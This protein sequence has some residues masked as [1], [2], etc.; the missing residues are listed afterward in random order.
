MPA[1]Q[2]LYDPQFEH[3]SCGVG[4]VVDI[5]GRKS[6]RIVTQAL[7]VL[8]NLLH[9][10]ACGCE[11]NTGDGAGI[12]IQMPHAFLARECGKLGITL[13]APRWY[14]AGLVFLPTDPSQ[15]ARCKAIFEEIIREEGQALLGWRDV[16]TDDSPVGPSAR[17]VEPIFTQIF[18]GRDAALLDDP[19]FERKLY[20]IRKRVEHAIYGSDMPARKLF[21]VPSLS[22][23]TL[24]YKGMLSA[25]QIET[26]FPDVLDPAVESA[27]ALVH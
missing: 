10:G 23:N 19:A 15:A 12:L 4:F 17:A 20:V 27:L 6:H 26:M 8:K 13:P 22:S 11:V 14:G 24:I 5:K 3:D 18:I 21:Y 16:P 1:R 25:D 7:S 2:G 9:R